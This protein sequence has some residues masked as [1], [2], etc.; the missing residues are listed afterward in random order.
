MLVPLAGCSLITSLDDLQ[1]VDGSTDVV[2][3]EAAPD[4]G[5]DGDASDGAPPGC[6]LAKSFGAP[7]PVTELDTAADEGAARLSH[8]ERTVYF[9]RSPSSDAGIEGGV[10]S[11]DIYVA[12]RASASGPFGP[13]TPLALDT[14]LA[15]GSPTTTADELTMFF[16]SNR[17]GGLGANDVWIATRANTSQVF[18]AKNGLP[19]PVNSPGD[20]WQP[21]T[22][23]DGLTLYFAT[24][25]GG[26]AGNLA[27]ATRTSSTAFV[28]DG[29]SIGA[30]IN[31]G[32]PNTAPVSTDDLTLYFASARTGSDDIFVS[33]RAS[34][35]VAFGAPVAVPN[36]NSGALDHPTWI[37]AD[38]CRM[39]IESDRAGSRDIYIA[40]RPP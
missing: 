6:D 38:G 21:Y 39:L 31:D 26:V 14:S 22:L 24:T 25:R 3:P 40:V 23:A 32:K 20:D 15:E 8:D 9:Q 34:T 5:A 30:N 12:T 29:T 18:V 16:T 33:T 11:Y 28:L 35:L 7:T 36:V 37:S 1:A 17:S 13:A 2:Q 10:G 27:R 19:N 4:A